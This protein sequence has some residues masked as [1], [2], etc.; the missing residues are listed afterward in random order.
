MKS[1]RPYWFTGFYGTIGIVTGEDE[2]TGQKR[3][4]IGTAP[5][6]NENLDTEHIAETGSPVDP[7]FLQ[8]ILNDL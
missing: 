7:T 3:A 2:I 8:L 5:G 6:F 1:L 4:Y